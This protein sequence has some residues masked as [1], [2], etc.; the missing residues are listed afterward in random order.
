[1]HEWGLDVVGPHAADP[2]RYFSGPDTVRAAELTGAFSDPSVAAVLAVRGGSGA[3]R[4]FRSLDLSAV[5]ANP[6][7]FVGFSDMTL[8]LDRF[9]VEADL[10]CFHGPMIGVDLPRISADARERFRRFLFGEADWFDGRARECWRDGV[11]EGPLKGGCLAVMVTTLGTAYEIDTAGSVLFI[12]DV[13]EPP[14]GIDRVLTHLKHA[15]KFDSVVG[16]AF[17]PMESC[18]GGQGTAYLRDICTD[19]LRDF[20][21][22]ILFGVDAGHGADNR[23]LPIG[24][25]TKIDGAA[26]KLELTES[27]FA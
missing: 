5:A 22:P 11:G 17:G 18:D 3:A 27:V 20:D 15:G 1:L 14:Y 6:K 25:R 9:L 21:F 4:T 24:A 26:L 13:A 12:E 2:L 16:V 10:L 8:L 19:V 7:I 23:V